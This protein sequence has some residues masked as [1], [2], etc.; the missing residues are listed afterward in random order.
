MG[1]GIIID[2]FGALLTLFLLQVV[3][4]SRSTRPGRLVGAGAVGI[5][6]VVGGRSAS[7]FG[8]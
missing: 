4:P 5:G 7:R 3:L 6:L 8:E 1:E 2:P